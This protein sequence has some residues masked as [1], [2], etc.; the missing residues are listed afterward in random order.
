MKQEDIKIDPE[1]LEKLEVL[2]SKDNI[3]LKN[4]IEI[5]IINLLDAKGLL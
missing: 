3:S 5:A 4:L 2:S 1:L